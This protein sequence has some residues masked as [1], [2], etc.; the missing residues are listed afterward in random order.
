MQHESIKSQIKYYKEHLRIV[1]EQLLAM[2]TGDMVRI[3]RSQSEEVSSALPAVS[4]SGSAAQH[5]D[6]G[7]QTP[8][9]DQVLEDIKLA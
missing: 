6:S 3:A 1:Q 9:D 4:A 8:L 5:T 7:T 2:S